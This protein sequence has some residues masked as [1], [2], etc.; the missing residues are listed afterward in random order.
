MS[1]DMLGLGS[2][3][4]FRLERLSIAA[5]SRI[6]GTMQGKRRSQMLGASLDFA[7]YRLY[8]P[9]DDTRQI[10][11][12]AFGRTGKPFIKLFLD[13]QELHVRLL[14]DVSASMNTGEDASGA[15]NKL[16]HAKRLAASIGY[17]ALA[18]YDRVSAGVFGETVTAS[19]PAMRGKGS[20]PRL[21]RFLA[22]A[23]PEP[24]GDLSRALARPGVLPRSPGMTWLFSDFLYE[25]G[26]RETLNLLLAAKQ[27]V[28]VIQVLSREELAPGYTGDLRLIDI[29]TGTGK[30]VAMS[31]RVLNLYRETLEAYTSELRAFCHERGIAYAL[32]PSDVPP[33]DWIQSELRASGILI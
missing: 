8:V 3:Q 24:K 18:G 13:E 32:A 33:A 29:E 4:L 2:E 30:E 27:E 16:A 17:I 20:A 26:V 19:L 25:S 31:A 14:V 9:G 1:G 28:A 7:D 23:A 22:E 6:R 12:N 5:K 10:D 21:F 15:G 11:W